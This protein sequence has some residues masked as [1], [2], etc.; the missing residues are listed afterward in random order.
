M[1]IFNEVNLLEHIQKLYF[2][3]LK[4]WMPSPQSGIHVMV[5]T[6]LDPL[7]HDILTMY[8]HFH[9]PDPKQDR[10]GL[11]GSPRQFK[12]FHHHTTAESDQPGA[13]DRDLVVEG[14]SETAQVA[15][16]DGKLAYAQIDQEDGSLGLVFYKA[17]KITSG[18]YK[19]I[20]RVLPRS[21]TRNL[22]FC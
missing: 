7:T 17:K 4:V 12:R 14:P 1:D 9:I 16:R 6:T 22:V 20:Q 18:Q 21:P 5:L 15:F 10:R 13:Q 19:A 11:H 3:L 8:N 2:F